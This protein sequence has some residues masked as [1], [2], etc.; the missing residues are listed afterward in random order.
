VDVRIATS[1]KELAGDGWSEF[2]ESCAWTSVFHT[3]EWLDTFAD[4]A[5][6]PVLPRHFVVMS[7]GRS[8]GVLPSYLVDDC[9]RMAGYLSRKVATP[10]PFRNSMLVAQSLESYH[11]GPLLTRDDDP[12]LAGL[13]AAMAEEAGRLGVGVFGLVNVSEDRPAL[14][15]ELHDLG[16]QIANMSPMSSLPVSWATYDEYRADVL[17]RRSGRRMRGLLAVAGA[18]GLRAEVLPG[19]VAP[20][21]LRLVG[22][23]MTRHGHGA[24]ARG[25]LRWYAG[26]LGALGRHARLLV[27]TDPGGN[28]VVTLVLLRHGDTLTIWLAGVDYACEVG[29]VAHHFA[30]QEAIRYAI[31]TGITRIDLGRGSYEFK[32]RH[33]Y[34]PKHA[35]LALKMVDHRADD[36]LRAWLTDVSQGCVDRFN[37]NSAPRYWVR[38][39]RFWEPFTEDN[40]P[41]REETG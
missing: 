3:A 15:D 23:T 11:G 20:E 4:V 5:P 24:D 17:R 2:A 35:F 41:T 33:G 36:A 27:V 25:D 32:R 29:A 19:P 8:S 12:A 7:G 26:L 14:L 9:P 28:T 31:D 22:A 30:H 38:P 1:I 21:R 34:R 10:A 40:P 39:R 37:A 18:A 16:F 13:C 6:F